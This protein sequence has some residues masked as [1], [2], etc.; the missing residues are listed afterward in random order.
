MF[1]AQAEGAEI[2]TIEGVAAG[3]DDLHPVQQAFWQHHGLQC[4]YCTP[5]MVLTA[6]SFFIVDSIRAA[7]EMM[8]GD[9]AEEAAA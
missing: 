5:G 1:A 8:S 6:M 3:V 4:G 7:A 9:S 2:T